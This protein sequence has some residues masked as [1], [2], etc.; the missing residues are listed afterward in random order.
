MATRRPPGSS[1]PASARCLVAR[2]VIVGQAPEPTDYI[3]LTCRN[4]NQQPRAHVPAPFFLPVAVLL[5]HP[6][7]SLLADDPRHPHRDSRLPATGQGA[8]ASPRNHFSSP[9][10]VLLR[11]ADLLASTFDGRDVPAACVCQRRLLRARPIRHVDQPS[12]LQPDGVSLAAGRQTAAD[13]TGCNSEVKHRLRPC[14]ETSTDMY[15]LTPLL[16][17]ACRC[18]T[19]P[20]GALETTWMLRCARSA[21]LRHTKGLAPDTSR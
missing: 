14:A 15:T 9:S 5:S 20:G 13:V 16:M 8:P 19:V 18:P 11:H 12:H 10:S 4:K 6:Q 3:R 1:W 2:C 17:P 7:A 21:L